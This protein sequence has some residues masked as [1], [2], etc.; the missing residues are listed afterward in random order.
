MH[1][2]VH[3]CTSMHINVQMFYH[4]HCGKSPQTVWSEVEYNH[5]C[6][7][8]KHFRIYLTSEGFQQLTVGKEKGFSNNT[9][10]S[11]TEMGENKK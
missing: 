10:F 4:G 9:C 8:E 1:I 5:N 7:T 11:L 3:R 2:D 6:G